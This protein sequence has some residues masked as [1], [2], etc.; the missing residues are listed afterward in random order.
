MARIFT[1]LR[2]SV[3]KL[4]EAEYFLARLRHSSGL[5]FQFE[6]N[7]FLSASRSLTFV[8][9][10]SMS[11]VP[12][13]SEWYRLQQAS[14]RADLAMRFFLELRNV[15]QKEGAGF[16]SRW[17]TFPRRAGATAS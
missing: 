4:L 13:F 7:A 1:T 6:L 12:H 8:L 10:K 5:E 16:H 15:S 14:M 9:Q 17:L 11:N 3:E 2:H